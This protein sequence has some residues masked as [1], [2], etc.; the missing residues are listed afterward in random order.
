[1]LVSFDALRAELNQI[2][3]QIQLIEQDA[4]FV[5]EIG[6]TH[7]EQA[8]KYAAFYDRVQKV[9]EF[10]YQLRQEQEVS[11]QECQQLFTELV[12]F[13]KWRPKSNNTDDQLKDFFGFW[14][15]FCIDFKDIFNKQINARIK[16]K[17]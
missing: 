11:L 13:F 2:E 17:S 5:R 6:E 4:N 3:K 1:M 8:E 9:V 7:S 16:F 15:P 10:A 12:E 14:L